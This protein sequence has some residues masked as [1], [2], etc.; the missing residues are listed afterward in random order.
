[1]ASTTANT[2]AKPAAAKS[3][4]RPKFASVSEDE[5]ET[6]LQFNPFAPRTA[7]QTQLASETTSSEQEAQE[8]AAEKAQALAAAQRLS[9]FRG[10]KISIVLKMSDGASAVRIGKRLIHEGEVV[11]GIRVLSISAEG[12]VVEPVTD[13]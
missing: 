4:P 12:I 9:E 7:L 2:A 10:Q 5:L 3:R 8:E 13:P 11:D 6:T 1:V